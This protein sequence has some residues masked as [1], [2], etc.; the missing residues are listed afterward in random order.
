MTSLPVPPKCSQVH[1]HIGEEERHLELFVMVVT[2]SEVKQLCMS[3]VP[4][5]WRW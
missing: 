3:P 1:G 5:H 4:D 2:G